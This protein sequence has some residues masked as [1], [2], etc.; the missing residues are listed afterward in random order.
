[1]NKL[2]F[3]LMVL[4]LGVSL[5]A[6]QREDMNTRGEKSR[7]RRGIRT[8]E[9]T[10]VEAAKARKEIRD[11]QEAKRDAKADGVIT[12][13]ERKV[14][15]REDRQADRTIHRVKHNNRRIR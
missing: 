2:F 12:A 15:A 7:L 14:I 3:Y 9:V 1:M 5:H 6:Q 11:V 8:G 13:Q 10:P 4:F